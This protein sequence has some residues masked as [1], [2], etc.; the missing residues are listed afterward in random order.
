MFFHSGPAPPRNPKLRRSAIPRAPTPCREH[1][2]IAEFHERLRGRARKRKDGEAESVV[3]IIDAQS[4][5]VTAPAPVTSRGHAPGK[6]A[7]GCKRCIV[8]DRLGFL[9]VV[10]PVT[11]AS[12]GDRDDAAILLQY[13][14]A[15]IKA[16]PWSGPTASTT[17]PLRTVAGT[18][19]P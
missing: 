6:E 17:A 5:R 11:A 8:T 4:A 1:G 14:A 13:L 18:N 2:L 16:W 3:G 7:P 9:L 10:V 15:R 12:N 19:S